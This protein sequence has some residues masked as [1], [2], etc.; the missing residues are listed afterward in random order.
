MLD[1]IPGKRA[2]AQSVSDDGGEPIEWRRGS[3]VS[4]LNQPPLFLPKQAHSGC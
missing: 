2:Q 3:L 4:C 1:G